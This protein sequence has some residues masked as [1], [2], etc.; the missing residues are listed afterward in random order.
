M[1]AAAPSAPWPCALRFDHSIST[2][3]A[4]LFLAGLSARDQIAQHLARAARFTTLNNDR[5]AHDG[6]RADPVRTTRTFAQDD[7]VGRWGKAKQLG[8]GHFFLPSFCK[9][10]SFEYLMPLRL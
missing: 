1:C 8:G 7:H 5:Q 6:V 9:M 10:N 4:S 3:S 2:S